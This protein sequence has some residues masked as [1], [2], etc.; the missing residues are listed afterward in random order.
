MLRV[1]VF[2]SRHGDDPSDAG[3]TVATPIIPVFVVPCGHPQITIA[4]D[5]GGLAAH[6]APIGPTHG[7]L[8]HVQEAF[9]GNAVHEDVRW[10]PGGS[11]VFAG[12]DA[13]SRWYAVAGWAGSPVASV[14]YR[15]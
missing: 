12:C 15:S 4:H 6:V 3:V 11:A 9:C 13:P 14:D 10:T 7:P 8:L 5:P 2:G 1:S